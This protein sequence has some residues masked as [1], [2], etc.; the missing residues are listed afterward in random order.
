MEPLGPALVGDV[1]AP[2]LLPGEVV[3]L[4]GAD[5]GRVDLVHGGLLQILFGEQ[6]GH[7]RLGG[8]HASVMQVPEGGVHVVAVADEGYHRH[9]QELAELPQGFR[10]HR[11]GAAEGVPGLGVEDG[12]VPPVHHPLELAHQ[13]HV[14][15]ELALADA[16]DEKPGRISVNTRDIF[17]LK[18]VLKDLPDGRYTKTFDLGKKRTL[19]CVNIAGLE[20]ESDI[21]WAYLNGRTVV[22][23]LIE[24]E[25]IPKKKRKKK[26]T[27]ITLAFSKRKGY[28]IVI[29]AYYGPQTPRF[30]DSFQEDDHR[31]Q[32]AEVFWRDHVLVLGNNDKIVLAPKPKWAN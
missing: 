9:L 1:D 12:D 20:L 7:L 24:R 19:S 8:L 10:Q 15:G 30:P 32:E 31:R 29:A 14:P 21:I 11:R 25:R 18:S 6:A 4:E 17:N 5:D 16:A 3:V 13:R 26:T 22:S 28:V 23:P 27:K 2:R